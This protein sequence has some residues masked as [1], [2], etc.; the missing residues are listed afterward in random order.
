MSTNPTHSTDNPIVAS[1][2]PQKVKISATDTQL[3]FDAIIV[4]IENTG[5]DVYL[6]HV[7]IDLPVGPDANQLV[8]ENKE[9]DIQ[10]E[11]DKDSPWKIDKKGDKAHFEI[12]PKVSGVTKILLESKKS[13]S[14]KLNNVIFNYKEGVAQIRVRVAVDPDTN[15]EYNLDITKVINTEARLIFTIDHQTID[16]GTVC[17]LSWD[18]DFI[19]T[20]TLSSSLNHDKTVYKKHGGLQ[21]SPTRTTD[22]IM[23]AKSKDTNLQIQ[24]RVTVFNPLLSPVKVSAKAV[25]KGESVELTWSTEYADGVKLECTDKSITLKE[26]YPPQAPGE[27]PSPPQPER[28][29]IGPI[30]KPITITAWAVKGTIESAKQHPNVVINPPLIEAFNIT[31]EPLA[32][33]KKCSFKLDW[34]IKNYSSFE[35]IEQNGHTQDT[36][37]PIPAGATEFVVEP[38]YEQTKYKLN[39][40]EIAK[41]KKGETNED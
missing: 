15:L 25:D 3:A 2:Y 16:P 33:N 6:K 20:Y 1:L 31:A 18:G 32:A 12:K 39:V 30:T 10:P 4:I 22:Y 17:N 13:F 14:F 21:V 5:P 9:E 40:F 35:I 7:Q 27:Q 38:A 41:P 11:D 8:L 36:R 19:D 37:L 23:D 28:V 26:K 34:R 24:R 29:F